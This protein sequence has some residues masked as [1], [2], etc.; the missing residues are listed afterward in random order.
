MQET[1][2]DMALHTPGFVASVSDL[3]RVLEADVHLDPPQAGLP[4]ETFALDAQRYLDDVAL[5]LA[6]DRWEPGLVGDAPV[7]AQL[8]RNAAFE[9]LAATAACLVHEETGHVAVDLAAAEQAARLVRDHV[10]SEGFG[11]LVR[12]FCTA[13]AYENLQAVE[14]Y[15]PMAESTFVSGGWHRPWAAYDLRDDLLMAA[16]AGG[17]RLKLGDGGGREIW[18]TPQGRQLL[19]ELR[20]RLAASGV[21]AE[22]H[23]LFAAA[24]R[25]VWSRTLFPQTQGLQEVWA[26]LLALAGIQTGSRVLLLGLALGAEGLIRLVGE[27]VGPSGAVLVVDPAAGVLRHFTQRVAGTLPAQVRVLPGRLDALP[28]SDASVDA[29]LAPS[30]LHL[31]DQERALAEVR[32]VVRPG[33]RVAL[34]LPHALETAHGLLREWLEPVIELA[35]RLD[36]AE[37]GR[38]HGLEQAADALARH[39]FVGL[40]ARQRTL[41]LSPSHVQGSAVWRG[42]LE[43]TPW[44]ERQR[45]LDELT[46][47]AERLWTDATAPQAHGELLVVSVPAG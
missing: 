23:R 8:G 17:V 15:Q 1:E 39:G 33:G 21:L 28:L 37:I 4:E 24:Q 43:R 35:T 22:R 18:L 46:A 14:F 12:A 45:V 47:R 41:P 38:Q 2:E 20:H 25:N 11:P 16:A 34:T 29:C 19:G 44:R 7:P 42:V 9:V 10:R 36:L 3:R 6:D 26:E 13:A 30:F 31:T 27:R 32:R 40:E 5:D